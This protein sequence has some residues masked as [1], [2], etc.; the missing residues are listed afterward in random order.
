MGD[1]AAAI[2]SINKALQLAPGFPPAL[3]TLKKIGAATDK[4]QK[5][6]RTLSPEEGRRNF[7]EC[8]FPVA[9]VSLDQKTIN[10]VI[11]AC[12]VLI[13][14][15]GDS[16]ENRANVHLQRGRMYRRL[17][18]YELALTDFSESTRY[19]PKSADA[20]TGRGNAYRGL[21]QLDQSI[22][23]HSEAIRLGPNNAA[24]HNN[25]G[26]AWRDTKDYDKAIADYDAAIKLSPHYASA[27][28]NRANARLD[29]GDKDGAIAD[30]RQ[31]LKV[32]PGLQQ[33]TDMLKQLG[34]KP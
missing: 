24:A 22:A 5:S 29:A 15:Q 28:Y 9:D 25:R 7:R 10:R 14:S 23:D 32:S 27:I 16:D 6:L 33:A 4:V 13:E 30:F 1:R 19:S 17:G 8:V 18:K 26:N 21:H 34:A 20:Y 2:A 31:A 3:E 12:T 11:S